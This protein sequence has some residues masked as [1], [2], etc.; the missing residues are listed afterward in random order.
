MA[1]AQILRMLFWPVVSWGNAASAIRKDVKSCL[2]KVAG[3][4][5]PA[6]CF[7]ISLG[8]KPQ[9]ESLLA[10]TILSSVSPVDVVFVGHRERKRHFLVTRTRRKLLA[11]CAIKTG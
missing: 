2:K 10:L 8:C 5:Q 3:S 7:G 4:F 1:I 6:Q 11:E 9:R